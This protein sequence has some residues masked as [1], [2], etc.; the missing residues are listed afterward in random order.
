MRNTQPETILE[1]RAAVIHKWPCSDNDSFHL[2]SFN[3][4][5]NL[6]GKITTCAQSYLD[7]V[8]VDFSVSNVWTVA[9][10]GDKLNSFSGESRIS[11]RHI[12]DI[13][14]IDR[15]SLVGGLEKLPMADLST[16]RPIIDYHTRGAIP[17]YRGMAP[18]TPRVR[19]IPRKRS[20]SV[21]HMEQLRKGVRDGR[22]LIFSTKQSRNMIPWRAHR[23]H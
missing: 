9:Q 14:P 21:D 15:A 23:R 18:P 12:Q 22:K 4:R 11:A 7:G 3:W 13:N 20:P 5:D 16:V 2:I 19:G 17:V 8:D 6:S 1:Y 10:A